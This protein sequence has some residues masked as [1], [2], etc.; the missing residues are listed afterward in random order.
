MT[1]C[2]SPRFATGAAALFQDEGVY[3]TFHARVMSARDVDAHGGVARECSALDCADID[4]SEEHLLE[5]YHTCLVSAYRQQGRGQGAGGVRGGE[6]GPGGVPGY[7]EFRRQY[8]L[9]FIDYVS[10]C[11]CAGGHAC[12]HVYVRACGRAGVYLHVSKSEGRRIRPQMPEYLHE[13]LSV[14]MPR[15]SAL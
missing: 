2:H 14:C 15:S 4:D 12:V 1:R 6:G 9:A 3:T 5:Y 13:C 10:V 11:A 7:D 8:R